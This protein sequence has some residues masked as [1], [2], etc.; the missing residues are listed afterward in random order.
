[1]GLGSNIGGISLGAIAKDEYIRHVLWFTV[2]QAL[3][4]TALSVGFAIPLARALHRRTWRF[5]QAWVQTFTGLAFVLP[6]IVAIFGIVSVH[7]RSGYANQALGWLGLDGG[8]YLYGLPG[9]L[10]AHT[11][12]NVPLAARVFLQGLADIPAEYWRNASQFGLRSADLFKVIEWP[13]LRGL[14]AGVSGIIFLLCFTSFVVVLTLGGGP[15]A[16]TLEVAIYQSLRLDFDIELAVGLSLLQIAS[17]LLI[18]LAISRFG[19]VVPITATLDRPHQRPDIDEPAAKWLDYSILGLAV[20]W[21][22]APLAAVASDGLRYFR[23]S[24]LFEDAVHQAVIGTLSIS[25]PAAFLATTLGLAVAYLVKNQRLSEHGGHV[26]DAA[27]AIGNTVLVVPPLVLGAGLF[28]FFHDH[29]DVFTIAPAILIAVN[30]LIALPFAIRILVPS[31]VHISQQTDRLCASLGIQ[32]YARFRSI[33]WPR[34]Q[35]AI[36]FTLAVTASLCAGELS[37]IALF[38]TQDFNT[39]PMLV[40]RLMGAYRMEQA[41]VA[42][43]L[44]CATCLTLFWVFGRLSRHVKFT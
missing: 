37:V 32:G 24:F 10:I 29:A 20:L 3:L 43:L 38:G 9:I 39:L 40:Y 22:G 13:T 42:A 16:T 33:T 8:H 28:L 1:M 14:L 19:K 44:L 7:G 2:W 26:A 5:G 41:A 31:V 11:F 27:E 36:G 30:G 34:M 4:S 23:A 18:F 17:C 6:S 25:V 15:G 12:F 35:T 21:I